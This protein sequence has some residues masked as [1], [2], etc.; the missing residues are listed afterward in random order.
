[1]SKTFVAFTCLSVLLG[2]VACQKNQQ[3]SEKTAPV[4]Q[5]TKEQVVQTIE[6]YVK[7]HLDADGTFAI[8]DSVENRT[9]H[10]K[11]DHV[12]E[13]VDTL[14]TGRYLACT[15]MK[16]GSSV[17]DLDFYVVDQNGKPAVSEVKI[18]KVDGISRK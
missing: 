9:R 5:L 2:F 10:L 18:H 16:E 12:H 6:D 14:G 13:S 3:K 1:M 4:V 8:E 7:G 17:L 11:F 15:D